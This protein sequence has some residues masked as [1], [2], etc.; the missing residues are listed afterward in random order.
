MAKRS[1]P[2]IDPASL[3]AAT[4]FCALVGPEEMLK[5]EALDN[6]RAALKA[7]HGDFDTS[8]FSGPAAT[9]ADVLDEVRTY[10]LLQPFKMVVVD[11]AEAFLRNEASR[12][13]LERYAQAPVDQAVLVL[14]SVGFN[15][16]RLEKAMAG[17]GGVIRCEPMTRTQATSWL[18]RRATGT[19]QR[20]LAPEAAAL[21]VERLGADLMRLDSEL[22]KLAVMAGDEE[23][24]TTP[25]IEQAVGRGS[26]EKAWAMQAAVLAA[27]EQG[28]QDMNSGV[29][30]QM[31]EKVH[32][33]VDLA[34]NDEVPV[35]YAIADLMRKLCYAAIL[36][37]RGANDGQIARSL[38]LWG[39]AR[40]AILAAAHKVPGALARRWFDR[41]ME[42]DLRNRS[43]LGDALRN[44]EGF[45]ALMADELQ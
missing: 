8:Y 42:L 19:Y 17:G 1:V 33:L 15:F 38:G 3:S 40:E 27:I 13:A 36:R 6:L 45:C 16:P 10:S 31:L 26:D 35:Y 23:P 25:M 7:A 37:Q 18:A 4:R 2:K 9:L 11:D 30:R 41:I 5:R 44:L 22:G 28:G 39:P 34:G 29:G 12:L 32:E 20:R 14:R 21:M 43:S 24:I